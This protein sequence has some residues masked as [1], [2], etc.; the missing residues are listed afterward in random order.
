MEYNGTGINSDHDF[1]IV[2]QCF[3][4]S[5]LKEKIDLLPRQTC[6]YLGDFSSFLNRVK[7]GDRHEKKNQEQNLTV[8]EKVGGNQVQDIPGLPWCPRDISEQT[9]NGSSTLTSKIMCCKKKLGISVPLKWNCIGLRMKNLISFPYSY[10]QCK[11][12]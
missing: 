12:I 3:S 2:S 7:E 6:F 9:H 4:F 8:S 5:A 1:S 10:L 11:I